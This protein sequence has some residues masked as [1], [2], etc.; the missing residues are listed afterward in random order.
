MDDQGK[1]PPGQDVVDVLQES[2]R[3]FNE[4]LQA[5]TAASVE[6]LVLGTAPEART[7]PGRL[8][9][10]TFLEGPSHKKLTHRLPRNA[11][12]DREGVHAPT[13]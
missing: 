9:I 13:R 12:T 4:Y 6:L 7:L 2:E 3:K 11:G 8:M 10:A 5:Y 1:I